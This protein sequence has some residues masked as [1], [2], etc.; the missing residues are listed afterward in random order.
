MMRDELLAPS[1]QTAG[2]TICHRMTHFL[3]T[4]EALHVTARRCVVTL[5]PKGTSSEAAANALIAHLQAGPGCRVSLRPSYEQ[6]GDDLQRGEA[7]V[8]IVANAYASINAFYMDPG[9]RLAAVFVRD[10]P[11]YGIAMRSGGA[12]PSAVRVATHPAPRPLVDEL[13]PSALSVDETVWSASTSAAASA[14]ADGEADVALTTVPAAERYDLVFISR[15]R[16]ITMVWSV[17]VSA[18]E[19][20]VPPIEEE[21]PSA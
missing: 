1:A 8:C 5:G 13:L 16:P 4:E 7:D 20:G 17:F 10:T 3:L 11:H 6:A 19:L 14:V 12:V 2:R 9:I 21:G 18:R 15:T